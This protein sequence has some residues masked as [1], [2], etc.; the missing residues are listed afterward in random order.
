MTAKKH[1]NQIVEP[2]SRRAG[3]EVIGERSLESGQFLYGLHVDAIKE[4]TLQEIIDR[5]EAFRFRSSDKLNEIVSANH[6]RDHKQVEGLAARLADLCS[7]MGAVSMLRLCYQIQMGARHKSELTPLI[8]KLKAEHKNYSQG[9][10][11][12]G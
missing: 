1:N 3:P 5:I 9:I 8:K 2:S 4:S 10:A 12:A 11:N 6:R 7:Q